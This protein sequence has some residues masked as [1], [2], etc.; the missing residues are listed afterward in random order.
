MQAWSQK[1]THA[2]KYIYI[3]ACIYKCKPLSA[4]LHVL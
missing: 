2:H 3:P 4:Y 1:N